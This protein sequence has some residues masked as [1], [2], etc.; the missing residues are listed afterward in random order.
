MFGFNSYFVS[1]FLTFF[2]ISPHYRYLRLYSIHLPTPRFIA[3]SHVRW[4][5][6]RKLY[7]IAALTEKRISATYFSLL[8]FFF[9]SA[10]HTYKYTTLFIFI[11]KSNSI[12][13][14][15]D[16]QMFSISLSIFSTSNVF[17]IRNSEK[18]QLV[19]LL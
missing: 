1:I 15:L 17:A 5:H 16:S 14:V 7:W 8:L 2:S 18:K 19:R 12:V 10:I 6:R 9:V 4:S 11:L 3:Y 13:G